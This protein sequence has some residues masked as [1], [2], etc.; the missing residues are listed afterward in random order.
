MESKLGAEI[1]GAELGAVTY[2]AEVPA[3]RANGVTRPKHLGAM[4]DGA[5]TCNLG[6]MTYGADPW[7]LKIDLGFPGV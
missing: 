2:G 1:C 4:T 6:A 5:E 3:T 7:G